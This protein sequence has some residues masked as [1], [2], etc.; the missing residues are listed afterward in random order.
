MA[1]HRARGQSQRLRFVSRSRVAD[2]AHRSH[3]VGR[4]GEL[5]D[6]DDGK[7]SVAAVATAFPS[8]RAS[9][10][11]KLADTE[12]AVAA[13]EASGAAAPA[14]PRVIGAELRQGF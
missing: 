10:R 14:D 3:G 1:Y 8:G 12:D 6:P 4:V 13:G 5:G 2:A 7:I 11:V 9:L